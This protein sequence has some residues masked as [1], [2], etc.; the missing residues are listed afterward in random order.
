[1]HPNLPSSKYSL[2]HIE[3]FCLYLSPLLPLNDEKNAILYTGLLL[4]SLLV[5]S[6]CFFIS[7][8]DVITTIPPLRGVTL[9]PSLVSIGNCD[10]LYYYSHCSSCNKSY[11]HWSTPLIFLRTSVIFPRFHSCL[12][13]INVSICRYTFPFVGFYY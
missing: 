7:E 12:Y 9:S 11:N 6:S 2:L 1:M 4:L 13:F 10:L 8:A 3:T 5:K